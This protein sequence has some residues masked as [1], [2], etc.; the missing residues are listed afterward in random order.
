MYEY[1]CRCDVACSLYADM[2]IRINICAG[3][4]LDVVYMWWTC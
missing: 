4:M 1:M 3:M 2:L